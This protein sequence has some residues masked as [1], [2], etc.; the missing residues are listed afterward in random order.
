M[1]Q[2]KL[3]I[4][5]IIIT[6]F[7]LKI[8]AQTTV[9]KKDTLT[10]KGNI[11]ITNNGI[12][13]VPTFSLGK[14]ALISMLSIG[15]KKFS[16]DPDLRFSLDA[17]PWAFVFWTRYK[18]LNTNKFKFNIGSNL[19]YAFK[20]STIIDIN[21]ITTENNIA[22]RY[23]ATELSPNYVISKN[24]SVGMYYLFSHG[25][26]EGTINNTH[27]VTFNT[28][29]SKIKLSESYSMSF[30]P[31]I[32]YLKMDSKNGYYFTSS[33]SFANKNCPFSIA[34][35]INKAVKTDIGGKDF[36]WNISLNYHLNKKIVIQ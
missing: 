11:S 26:D 27:F 8:A 22:Q 3:S 19:G 33:L 1:K 6:T 25:V 12:S 36:N 13:P 15:G 14:P 10:F 7:S 20:N 30:V 2:L 28:N 23:F 9:S 32:Y 16:F 4:K 29:F 21:G 17:K 5:L 34:T 35:V 31:Q 24:I 18:V